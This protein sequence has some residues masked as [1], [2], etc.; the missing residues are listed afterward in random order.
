VLSTWQGWQ[1]YPYADEAA[2]AAQSLRRPLRAIALLGGDICALA[3][4]ATG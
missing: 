3:G 1:R 4:I 2:C